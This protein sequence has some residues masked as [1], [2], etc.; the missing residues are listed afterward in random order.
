MIFPFVNFVFFYASSLCS[1]PFSPP[2]LLF[3][4][5]FHIYL[6]ACLYSQAKNW[7]PLTC[8]LILAV[9]IKDKISA[10]RWCEAHFHVLFHSWHRG[11]AKTFP[12]DWSFCIAAA[13]LAWKEGLSCVPGCRMQGR[14]IS[15]IQQQKVAEEGRECR[16][17]TVPC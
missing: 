11:G 13:Y 10:L 5:F 16:Q 14:R 12:L 9:S 1:L 2:P 8:P 3:F 17:G 15:K 4:F 6:T 7:R